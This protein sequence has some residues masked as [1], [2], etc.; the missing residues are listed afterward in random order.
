[1]DPTDVYFQIKDPAG[2]I[3]T[4]HYGDPAGDIAR[5]SAGTYSSTINIT[6]DGIWYQRRYSTG[7]G[8]AAA[9]G[10]IDALPSEFD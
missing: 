4:Y 3:T 10:R 7:T 9:E 1:M 2:T 5:L 6:D 8:T